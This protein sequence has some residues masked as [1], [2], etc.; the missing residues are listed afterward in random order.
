VLSRNG[1]YEQAEATV[2]AALAHFT[3]A[4]GPFAKELIEPYLVLGDSFY[5]AGDF[6]GAMSAYGEAR[7]VSRRV[8][9]LLNPGQIEIIDRMSDTAASLGQFTDAQNLQ[10]ESLTLIERSYDAH[11]PEALDAI[12]KYA[13]WLRDNNYFT[14]EREQ[15]ALADRTIRQYYGDASNLLVRPLR[16]RANSFRTQGVE[17]GLGISG[18]RDA[19]EILAQDP[20][21]LLSAEVL[22]DMGDWEVAFSKTGTDGLEYLQA[23]DLLAQIEETDGL[24]HDW[25]DSNVIVLTGPRSNRGLSAAPDAPWGNVILSFTVDTSGRTRDVEVT[26]SSPPGLKDEAFA[27]Q[28]RLSRFRP[29]IRD[30]ELISTRRTYDIQFQYVTPDD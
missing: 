20:D 19:E 27:R 12:Y 16:E 22:R 24:R 15:Y 29:M 4:N 30:G 21:P 28:F 23:W 10:L 8:D 6:V 3:E 13:A 9:G 17:Q 7:T 26:E 1:D 18:L 11:A 5:S 2:Q 25:F 14:I